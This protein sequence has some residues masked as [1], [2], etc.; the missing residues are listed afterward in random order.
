MHTQL[1]ALTLLAAVSLMGVTIWLAINCT[2][3][4]TD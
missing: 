3:S 2:G 4:P 1:T